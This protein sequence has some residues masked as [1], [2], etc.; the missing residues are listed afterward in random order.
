[1]AIYSEFS[2]WKWWFAIAMLVYQ[3]VVLMRFV[4]PI[5]YDNWACLT[6]GWAP[7]VNI[8]AIR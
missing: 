4:Y 3:R 6:M 8:A 7:N 1:M 2:H 5:W